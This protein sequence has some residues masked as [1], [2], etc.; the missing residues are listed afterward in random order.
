MVAR[1]SILFGLFNPIDDWL[2]LRSERNDFNWK[3]C[4]KI[5]AQQH[6]RWRCL[7][8]SFEI[9]RRPSQSWS[10]SLRVPRVHC[11]GGMA[12]RIWSDLEPKT[13]IW[14]DCKKLACMLLPRLNCNKLVLGVLWQPPA[15]D[16]FED[17]RKRSVS[18]RKQSQLHFSTLCL[19]F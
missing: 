19:I 12:V 1:V 18:Q 11:R 9:R 10:R 16:R 17:D 15:H 2:R 5:L 7:W 3:R 4:F 13:T 6:V 14:D 8:F